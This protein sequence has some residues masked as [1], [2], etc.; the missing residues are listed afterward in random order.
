MQI[1]MNAI[2]QCTG[3]L[4][5]PHMAGRNFCKVGSLVCTLGD[6]ESPQSALPI[7][8]DKSIVVLYEN[9]NEICDT[10]ENVDNI[11]QRDHHAHFSE[12]RV[13]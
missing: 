12:N 9:V 11:R 2:I 7:E 3:S 8:V 5:M 1:S 4:W 10:S 13:R 6:Q